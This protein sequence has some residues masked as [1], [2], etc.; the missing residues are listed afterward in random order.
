MTPAAAARNWRRELI[1]A[2]AAYQASRPGDP[3]L[4]I[5]CR[6]RVDGGGAQ[7]LAVLSALLWAEATGCRY[8][9]TP[10]ASVGHAVGSRQAWAAKWEAFLNLGLG[11]T[12]VPVDARIISVEEFLRDPAARA[13]PGI[14][15]ASE[16]FHYHSFQ[17]PTALER[18][19]PAFRAKYHAADKSS[20]TLHRGPSDALVVAVHVRRGDVTADHPQRKQFYTSDDVNLRTIELVRSVAAVR[21]RRVDVHIFSEGPAEMFS[22]FAAA[23]C[24]LHLD[25]DA[26]E[27][28]HNLVSADILVQAKSSF[29]Y[30]AGLLSTGV[31]LHH[32]YFYQRA[33][34]WIMRDKA[35][36]F[37]GKELLRALPPKS[38]QR[39]AKPWYRRPFR[40]LRRWLL[41]A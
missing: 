34:G 9:H 20:F 1:A 30:M 33:P 29:S 39:R 35:G 14:V 8:L 11:E 19:R 23:D 21:G 27:A 2:V 22:A 3:P 17:T 31:V 18:L 6:G 4:S 25:G 28:F 32:R 15:L 37:Q 40:R 7:A 13:E 38:S 36:A 26:L 12:P 16:D 5:T 41:P 24:R 10:F